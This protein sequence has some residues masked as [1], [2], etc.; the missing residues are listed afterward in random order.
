MRNGELGLS[1]LKRLGDKSPKGDLE[2]VYKEIREVLTKANG[3]DGET[4]RRN[5]AR[6]AKQLPEGWGEGGSCQK[7]IQN[8]L[9]LMRC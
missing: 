5:A 4:K 7:D 9:D 6:I 1:P 2:S 8:L 3:E